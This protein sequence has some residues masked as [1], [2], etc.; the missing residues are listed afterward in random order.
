MQDFALFM[1]LQMGVW[2]DRHVSMWMQA[3][4][5][6]IQTDLAQTYLWVGLK[7]FEPIWEIYI[8]NSDMHVLDS[9][10][11]LFCFLFITSI[12]LVVMIR[13]A[14]SLFY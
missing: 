14:S 10:L 12:T 3:Q 5:S 8:L 9:D 4:M 11:K 13:F 1:H 2:S 7:S 6:L